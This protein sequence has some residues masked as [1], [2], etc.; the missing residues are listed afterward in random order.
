MGVIPSLEVWSAEPASGGNEVVGERRTEAGAPKL[1]GSSVLDVIRKGMP[2]YVRSILTTPDRSGVLE[3]MKPL[4]RAPGTNWLIKGQAL[5]GLVDRKAETNLHRLSLV[6]CRQLALE[7]QLQIKAELIPPAV[8][9]QRVAEARAAFDAVLFGGV[10]RKLDDPETP[11]PGTASVQASAGIRLPT[12]TGAAL[13]LNNPLVRTD[14]D[15]APFGAPPHFYSAAPVLSLTQ[16]L[17]KG[18]GLRINEASIHRARLLHRQTRSAAKLA[19]LNLLANVDRVYWQLWLARGELEIRHE[20]YKLAEQQ[21]SHARRM[22]EAGIVPKIEIL[23]SEVG[24]SQRVNS[25]I[26]ADTTRRLVEREL[27]RVLNYTRADAELERSLFPTTAPAL[28]PISV[29]PGVLVESAYKQRMDLM[30]TQIQLAVDVLDQEVARNQMLPDVALS[31]D[32]SVSSRGTT[33]GKAYEALDGSGPNYWQA[34]VSVSMPLGN[35]AA[36]ARSRQAALRHAATLNNVEQRRQFIQQDVEN[37][38]DRLAQSWQLIEASVQEMAMSRRIYD[39]E[40][41]QFE[42]GVRTSTE[43]LAAAQFLANAQIR[44]LQA[45]SDYEIAKVEL[46]Y[47]TGTHLGYSEVVLEEAVSSAKP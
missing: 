41:K 26:V 17:L 6:E 46:A 14:F 42:G 16:P 43:V 30:S 20:Q 34:G 10:S 7:R 21:L 33:L 27:R 22:V 44:N 31:F 39:G 9:E 37:A 1:S 12:R 8:A 2:D 5:S 11:A 18:A 23:R 32:Y 24:M 19:V 4:E 28:F 47:A 29:N 25:I 3:P 35:G 36:R 40:V 45:I 38:V 13:T 15:E